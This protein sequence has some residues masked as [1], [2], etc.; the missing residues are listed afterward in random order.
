[1]A[2]PG[3]DD[4]GLHRLLDVDYGV[5]LMLFLFGAYMSYGTI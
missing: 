1:M 5:T 3:A 4:N 2:L